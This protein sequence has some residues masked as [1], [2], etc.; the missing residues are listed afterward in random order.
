[1]RTR[2]PGKFSLMDAQLASLMDVFKKNYLVYGLPDVAIEEIAE[3][4]E[5][6]VALAGEKLL[7][8]GDKSSDLFVVLDGHV[9]IYGPEGERIGT[10]D[11]P[12]VL[13]EIALVDDLG[14]TADAVCAGLVKVVRLP[15]KELRK[16]MSSK[17][18]Y[19]F[20]ML[21]NLSRVLSMRLRKTNVQLI[22]LMGKST[23]LWKN[24]T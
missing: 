2:I 23:D 3:L 7:A 15:G 17:K 4:G 10:V 24:V 13:G 12:S 16:C 8:K 6:K 9:H 22:N 5:F 20:V 19:G 18:E 14:R 1:M 21:S 11:P